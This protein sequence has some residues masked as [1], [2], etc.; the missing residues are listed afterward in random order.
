MKFDVVIGNPPYQETIE[1][2]TNQ[3][4]VYQYF[5]DLAHEISQISCLISP[6]RFLSNVGDTP[7]SWN[8]KI[9]NDEH[10]KIVYH[11]KKSG[12]IFPN[13]DIVGGVVVLLRDS[14]KEFGAIEF[15][16][17]YDELGTILEKVENISKRSINELLYSNT[18][19]RYSEDLFIDYPEFNDRLSGGSRRYLTSSVFDVLHEVFNDEKPDDKLGYIKVFGRQNLKRTHKFMLG[20]YLRNHENLEKF[21]VYLP[22][23]NGSG[24]IGEVPKTYIIG[25]PIIGEPYNA[26]TE[27]FISFGAFENKQESENLKK[28]LKSKFARTMLGILKVTPGNKTKHVWSKVPLQDFTDESD[29]DWCKSIPEIDQQLYKKYGLSEEEICFIEEKIREMD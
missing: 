12:E 22:S 14:S 5:Y 3:P 11:E 23:S 13:T 24:A 15:F 7:V 29:I 10:I 28:Y 17:R 25:K 18:S 2:R 27:T 21:K 6:A 20:K 8:K 9:L 16:I 26:A 1:N 19:Y 4:S